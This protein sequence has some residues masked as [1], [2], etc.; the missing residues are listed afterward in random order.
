MTGSRRAVWLGA[1]A[2]RHPAYADLRALAAALAQATGATLGVLAE[3]GNAA[4]AYLAGAV[5][6]REA[7]GAPAASAGLSAA[8]DAERP[9]RSA[10]CFLAVWSPGRMRLTSAEPQALRAARQVIAITPYASER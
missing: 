3:G 4:G 1:L 8:A 10:R 5:P 7:G 2:L 6:H 9:A